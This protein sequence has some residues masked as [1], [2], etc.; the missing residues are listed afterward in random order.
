MMKTGL[1]FGSFNP[2]HVGHL[3]IANYMLEFTD[4]ERLWFVVSPQNPMKEKSSLLDQ[5]HRFA[6]IQR[7]IEDDPRLKVSDI[8]FRLPLPSYTINTL[9]HLQE[10]YPGHRFV[11]LTGSDN[12]ETFHKW[13]NYEHIL[14]NYEIY[15]YPRPG[16]EG[17]DLRNHARVKWVPAPHIEISAS[18]LRKALREKRDMRYF[19]PERAYNYIR[20]MHF[21]E[22]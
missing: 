17:G 13:K 14:E 20:E 18:F 2:L 22:K 6:I 5:R 10:K 3:V 15:V 19:I 12:L 16:H 1:F 8:E 9:V 7:A 11:L 21:Y 4:L